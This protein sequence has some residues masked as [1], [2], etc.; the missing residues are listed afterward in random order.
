MNALPSTRF[1]SSICVSDASRRVVLTSE[2]HLS[3]LGRT[4]EETVGRNWQEWMAE[5]E[6]RLIVPKFDKL[7]ANKKPYEVFSNLIRADGTIVPFLARCSIIAGDTADRDLVFIELRTPDISVI[8]KTEENFQC[9]SFVRD[10]TYELAAYTGRS[11]LRQ[12]TQSLIEA[13]AAAEDTLEK[14]S[15]VAEDVRS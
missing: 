3:L 5:G 6:C 13:S 8:E 10:L 1:T 11:K 2:A 12:L 15:R 14:L 4:R 9:A 7:I